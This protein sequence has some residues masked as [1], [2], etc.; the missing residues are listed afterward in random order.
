MSCIKT[1]KLRRFWGMGGMASAITQNAIFITFGQVFLLF[2][3]SNAHKLDLETG[4]KI[5]RAQN[6]TFIPFEQFSH[7]SSHCFS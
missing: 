6:V 7:V 1:K 2:N 3:L 4:L 5:C